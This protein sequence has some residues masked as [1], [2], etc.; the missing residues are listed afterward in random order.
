[1]TPPHSVTQAQLNFYDEAQRQ[2]TEALRPAP[3]DA[4]PKRGRVSREQLAAFLEAKG[5]GK[6]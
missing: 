1:M 5:S 6:A 2:L 3:V 4:P